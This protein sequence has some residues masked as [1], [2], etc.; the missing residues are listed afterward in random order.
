MEEKEIFYIFR[1]DGSKIQI[2]G[3]TDSPEYLYVHELQI[4]DTF[5]G[6]KQC[7]ITVKSPVPI[8]WKGQEYITVDDD[9]FTLKYEPSL[10]KQARKNTYGEAFVYEDIVLQSLTDET[11]RV[12][13]LDYVLEDNNIHYS[14]MPTVYFYGTVKDLATRI[15]AN[16]DRVY[17]GDEKWTVKLGNDL[18]TTEKQKTYEK[19]TVW[20]AITDIWNEYEVLFY[21]KGR[22]LYVG[23]GSSTIPHDFMYGVGN[24][25]KSLKRET[26][27]SNEIITRLHVYGSQQNLPY[28]YYNK[29]GVVGSYYVTYIEEVGKAG[30]DDYAIKVDLGGTFNSSMFTKEKTNSSVSTVWRYYD[31]TVKIE[32]Y[33]CNVVAKVFNAYAQNSITQTIDLQVETLLSGK[34]Y[35]QSSVV[36]TENLAPATYIFDFRNLTLSLGPNFSEGTAVTVT[37]IEYPADGQ[38]EQNS[39]TIY[40]S[41][42]ATSQGLELNLE[43]TTFD[44]KYTNSKIELLLYASTMTGVKVRPQLTGVSSIYA[45]EVTTAWLVFP[46]DISDELISLLGSNMPDELY[47]TENINTQYTP[48]SHTSFSGAIISGSMYLPNLMLPAIRIQGDATTY[49]D[50]SFKE[51]TDTASAVYRMVKTGYGGVDMDIYLESVKGIEQFGVLEGTVTFD[52]DSE[53]DF[54]D[55]VDDENGIYP[56]LGT[57]TDG[58]NEV[59]SAEQLTDAGVFDSNGNVSPTTFS[60]VVKPGFNPALYKISG[61]DMQISFKSGALIGR[62]FIFDSSDN[63]DGTYTLTCNRE[64]DDSIGLSFPNSS[65]NVQ[66]G[67]KFVFLGIELPDTYIQAAETRLLNAGLAYLANYDHT[68]YVY[69]PEI[70]NIFLACAENKEVRDALCA[71][72]TFWFTDADVN[73]ISADEAVT[74]KLPISKLVTK[75]GNSLI[76]EYEV[77]LADTPDIDSDFVQRTVSAVNNSYSSGGGGGSADKGTIKI[78]G[79]KYYL[80]KLRDDTAAGLITFLKG[81]KI[82]IGDQWEITDEGKASLYSASVNSLWANSKWGISSEGIATLKQLI[83]DTIQAT[84]ITTDYLTVTKKAHF[85]ELVIDKLKSVGGTVVLTSANCKF[86]K[87]VP[88]DADGN[89]IADDDTTTA[90]SYWR[91]YWRA[92][93]ADGNQITNDW[94]VNDQAIS[95]TCNFAEGTSYNVGNR[96]WWRLV[97]GVSDSVTSL[98]F[99]G[100]TY[101]CHY[102]DISNVTYDDGTGETKLTSDAP[103]AGDTAMLLGSRGEDEDRQNAIVL[104]ASKWVDN[105]RAATATS[106][107]IEAIKCP[108]I[109]Q[110]Q[111]ITSFSLADARYLVL[112]A[113]GNVLRGKVDIDTSGLVSY[114][115]YAYC[116]DLTDASD[117]VKQSEI[118]PDG[119]GIRDADYTYMGIV[120]DHTESDEA[121]TKSD[122]VWTKTQGKDGAAG[123]Q[124]EKGDKGDK[125]DTGDKGADGADGLDGMRLDVSPSIV[126]IETDV[127]GIAKTNS[128]NNYGE[129]GISAWFG[130]TAATVSITQRTSSGCSTAMRSGSTSVFQITQIATQTVSTSAGSATVSV[131]SGSVT[132]TGTATLGSR[133]ESFTVTIPFTVNVSRQ[134]A[135]IKIDNDSITSTV[136]SL[137]GSVDTLTEEYSQIKQESD[138]ISLK[139]GSQALENKRWNLIDGG[140]INA[141]WFGGLTP[142][143]TVTLEAGKTYTLTAKARS[144]NTSYYVGLY[145]TDANWS[146][147]FLL[148]FTSDGAVSGTPLTTASVRSVSMSITA[149]QEYSIYAYHFL[150]GSASASNVSTSAS[151]GYGV[152]DWITVEEGEQ[153][154]GDYVLSSGDAFAASNMLRGVRDAVTGEAGSGYMENNGA[155]AVTTREKFDDIDFAYWTKTGVSGAVMLQASSIYTMQ[156]R[157]SYTLSFYAKASTSGAALRVLFPNGTSASGIMSVVCSNGVANVSKGYVDISL[158]ATWTRYWVAFLHN[159]QYAD[160]GF[161]LIT[162]NGSYTYYVAALKLRATGRDDDWTDYGQTADNPTEVK[163]LATGLDIENGKIIAT[164]DNFEVRNNSGATTMRVNEHGMLTVNQ[165]NMLGTTARIEI[166]LDENGVPYLSALYADGSVA[167]QFK[168]QTVELGT[169]FSVSIQSNIEDSYIIFLQTTSGTYNMNCTVKVVVRNNSGARLA[170]DEDSATCV[171][172]YSS[173]KNVELPLAKGA[174]IAAGATGV[175]TYRGTLTG[176]S[177]SEVPLGGIAYLCSVTAN[178]VGGSG[179]SKMIDVLT[180]E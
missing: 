166:G 41:P 131:G 20:D 95:Y 162:Q 10:N 158:T 68:K 80:S 125:G 90:V 103:A 77:T 174:T 94:E 69:T 105:G 121:L 151:D 145:L 178:A 150:K 170:F 127:N 138:S 120:S 93:D 47:L 88:Y 81:I 55:L 40:P 97:V 92:N 86:D 109:V 180:S 23:G 104:A 155:T 46:T 37:L 17:T 130:S 128:A 142:L 21:T 102:I 4:E 163:T 11:T 72:A 43:K 29:L 49:Y 89:V 32:D 83:V 39:K 79:D 153:S 61:D 8:T 19:Q 76:R 58:T 44:V 146:Q 134:A 144:S 24:G 9:K 98:E 107:A 2:G 177:S 28:R 27:E 116:N 52:N 38:S 156:A 31:T 154:T 171:V 126:T 96:Y 66:A 133:S 82:G 67:D 78:V 169:I 7:T 159:G 175:V 15:Q 62:T 148:A 108:A 3:T 60:V 12:K 75:I 45:E 25:L 14:A 119:S 16:L 36:L 74:I 35:G 147:S 132:V 111:K 157:E 34:T 91:C 113:N 122:Y 100:A 106:E 176:L 56:N 54:E 5:L 33:T 137:E 123:A 71:G 22:T 117:F 139:V 6:Q 73:G 99:D 110:Y 65:Y 114:T 161:S 30:H 51:T 64:N 63:G 152:L 26:D 141:A 149:T 84:D 172:K 85:F 136:S 1:K 59:V 87:V 118:T 167:W 101:D 48:S 143:R 173:T 140:M 57:A 115:H 179:D 13:F 18:P 50:A 168:G 70:D 164:A 53:T 124:G 165:L 129:V 160:A 42:S 135:S 112:A